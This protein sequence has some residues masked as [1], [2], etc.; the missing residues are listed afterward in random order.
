MATPVGV[1]IAQILREEHMEVK[2]Q[3]EKY[4]RMTLLSF[5]MVT[6]ILL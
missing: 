1:L 6:Q 2:P 3:V 5:S 4:L